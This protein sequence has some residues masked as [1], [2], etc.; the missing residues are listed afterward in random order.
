VQ[1]DGPAWVLLDSYGSAS[2]VIESASPI[3]SLCYAPE[4]W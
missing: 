3:N 4:P 1:V 2:G